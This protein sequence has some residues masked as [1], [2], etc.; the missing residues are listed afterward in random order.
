MG[1]GSSKSSS[2]TN[3]EGNNTTTNRTENNSRRQKQKCQNNEGEEKEARNINNKEDS[4]PWDFDP[5]QVHNQLFSEDTKK[6]DAEKNPRLSPNSAAALN[7]NCLSNNAASNIALSAQVSRK[8]D[9]V[10]DDVEKLLSEQILL[11][12]KNAKTN[13]GSTQKQQQSPSST[14]AGIVNSVSSIKTSPDRSKASGP[15]QKSPRTITPS[16]NQ[17]QSV[18]D[19][20]DENIINSILKGT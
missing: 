18:L 12:Q 9:Q 7:I 3:E 11:G 20:A 5:D 16:F 6:I 15:A 19:E 10:L 13:N 1:A 8:S 2:P 4:I 17:Q 14:A